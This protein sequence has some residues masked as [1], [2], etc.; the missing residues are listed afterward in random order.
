MEKITLEMMDEVK[1]RT[2]VTY[3]KAKEAL[4]TTGGD[5]IGAII[6]LEREAKPGTEKTFTEY[7]TYEEEPTKELNM[8]DL[9]DLEELGDKLKEI[10]EKGSVTRI[11]LRKGAKVLMSVPVT[12][13]IAGGIIGAWVAPWIVI[14][15]ALAVY[16][17]KCSIDIIKEDGTI[18]TIFKRN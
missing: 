6:L 4:E 18:E 1:T 14:P 8:D 16:G 7:K 9:P 11:Q 15:G 5:V 13:G 12:T 3:E 10:I 17:T 2:G